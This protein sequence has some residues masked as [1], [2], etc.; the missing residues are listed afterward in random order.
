MFHLPNLGMRAVLSE[1]SLHI[2][3]FLTVLSL[4]TYIPHTT[5]PT[6][7]PGKETFL[8]SC[9]KLT[10]PHTPRSI[11]PIEYIGRVYGGVEE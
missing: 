9:A 2:K 7:H 6:N 5:D 10:Y 11:A 8:C 1:P 3:D 4:S